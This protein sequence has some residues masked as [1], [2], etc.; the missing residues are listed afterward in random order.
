MQII[1]VENQTPFDGSTIIWPDDYVATTA[2]ITPADLEPTDLPSG[3]DAPTIPNDP[4]AMIATSYKDQLFYI[5][6]PACYKIVRTWKVLDWCQHSTSNPDIGIWK[7]QQVI[8]VM[9]TDPPNIDFCPLDETIELN[10]ACTHAIVSLQPVMATGT[11]SN[12]DIS[13][14]N[15]SPYANS[16][17]A[18]ASGDYPEGVHTVTF[19]VEDGC[20]NMVQCST[21]IT[22]SDLKPPTPFCKDGLVGE[23]QFMPNAS[24]QIMAVV[25]ASQLNDKSFDNCTAE[26]DLVYTMRPVGDTITPVP[27]IVYDC[28]GEGTHDVEIWVTDAAGN[29]DFCTTEVIIQDNMDL[30]PDTLTASN[31]MI[32][33][34]IQTSEGD[35]FPEVHVGITSL[36]MSYMTDAG[37]QYEF[38][39]LTAGNDYTI[40]P[41]KNDEPKNG[42][43]TYDIVLITRHILGIQPLTD[44][45]NLIAGDVNNS[46][47][48][49]TFDVVELRKLILGILQDF[50][51]NNSWRFV[52]TD[53]VFPNPNT[54]SD[55]PFPEVLH[56]NNL[57]ADIAD[58]DFV[59][60]KIGD[61]NASASA[62]FA[63]NG[64][65]DR[66]TENLN[67]LLEDRKVEAGEQFTVPFRL[68]RE[69]DLLALQFTLEF[70]TDLELQ[71][72]EKG[73]LS[74][75]AG[76]RFETTQIRDGIVTGTWYHTSP[77]VA[78][79]EDA[80]F[81]LRFTCQKT[82]ML[83]ELIAL[84]SRY[85]QAIAYDER[86]IP[87]NLN[88]VFSNP[89]TM[90]T[91]LSFQLHQNQP[92][93]FKRVTNI[94][95]TLPENGPAT[96]TIYDVSGNVIKMYD[97]VYQQ[98]YNEVSIMRQELPIG[99]VLFYQLQTP[100][101]T[102]T[103]KMILLQ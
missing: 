95:F 19:T 6:F 42:I 58:A 43:T 24:P 21:V 16:N 86:E 73:A 81:S 78:A 41:W 29:S 14:T 82:G 51:N 94:G 53:Y 85:T 66:A 22:V 35:V 8:A 3:F 70:E 11:C 62:N 76:D 88:L 50:P 84:T 25:N 56:V 55:P 74:G 7:K 92:N 10:A 75:V 15:N 49:T 100:S 93:P 33:G 68:E 32:G 34:N 96:L 59:G 98:G 65:G 77:V 2:C 38:Q 18:D 71:G 103:K 97:N 64:I 39:N 89:I 46:G 90:Q 12:E 101:H 4:C 5:D 54:P 87:L 80:L 69:N 79:K 60:V 27:F 102:A 91:N 52:K 45:Y 40:E 72:I 63:G 36:S 31:G 99:G 61:V 47:A 67:I 9:D 57:S 44:P 17:G 13:I 20:G 83:S 30:C 48:I 1:T 23:L 37:G 26:A 28:D